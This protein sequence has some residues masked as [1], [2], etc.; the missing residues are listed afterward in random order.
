MLVYP[1]PQVPLNVAKSLP[2]G[3]IIDDR[4]RS[5]ILALL[6]QILTLTLL[7]Q[8]LFFLWWVGETR[9]QLGK[10]YRTL[11]GSNTGLLWDGGKRY[12][13]L[14]WQGGAIAPKTLARA[15]LTTY[16]THLLSL[17]HRPPRFLQLQLAFFISY[18]S[19]CLFPTHHPYKILAPSL[20]HWDISVVTPP[21]ARAAAMLP[22]PR[23]AGMQ[24]RFRS[25][26]GLMDFFWRFSWV[27]SYLSPH[28][29]SSLNSIIRLWKIG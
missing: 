25:L 24:Y 14:L 7:Y 26:A 23:T 20:H 18:S 17:F 16:T 11:E 6:L 15:P 10:A 5:P 8:I 22:T 29:L 2:A 1:L 28:L 9:C 27:I 4:F 13:R 21:M 3:P 12:C 19:R